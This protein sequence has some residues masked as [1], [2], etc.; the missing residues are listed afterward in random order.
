MRLPHGA[1]LR[2]DQV[3]RLFASSDAVVPQVENQLN[4]AHDGHA[5][6]RLLLKPDRVR[7]EWLEDDQFFRTGWAPS[8]LD[9]QAIKR[10][11]PEGVTISGGDVGS[12]A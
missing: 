11:C 3:L 1:Q 12:S 4:C 10:A 2:L 6:D 5:A 9:G 8:L 7:V